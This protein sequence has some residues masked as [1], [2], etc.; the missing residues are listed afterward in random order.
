M[1][2]HKE[3]EQIFALEPVLVVTLLGRNFNYKQK[4]Q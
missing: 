3:Q 4:R 2:Q 1:L